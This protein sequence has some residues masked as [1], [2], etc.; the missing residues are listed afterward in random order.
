MYLSPIKSYFLVKQSSPLS[1]T[2]KAQ[3]W[4]IELKSFLKDILYFNAPVSS[5]DNLIKEQIL[6]KKIEQI[7]LKNHNV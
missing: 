1:L 3:M 7:S 5:Q 4:Y 6:S 2:A